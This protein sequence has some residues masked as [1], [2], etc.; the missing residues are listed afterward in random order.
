MKSPIWVENSL[1]QLVQGKDNLAA[2]VSLDGVGINISCAIGRA[3]TGLVIGFC[4]G[5]CWIPQSACREAVA[6]N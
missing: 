5:E 3:F 1:P 2:A 4:I 6:E